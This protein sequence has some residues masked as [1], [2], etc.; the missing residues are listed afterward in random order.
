MLKASPIGRSTAASL[1]TR[2]GRILV[3]ALMFLWTLPTFGILVSSFRPEVE[4]KT[5]GWWN[6]FK[7]PSFTLDNY[8]S[9]LSS[10]PG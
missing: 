5:S 2:P 10:A 6:W 7:S 4:V 3:Y 8:D 9:V 1:S